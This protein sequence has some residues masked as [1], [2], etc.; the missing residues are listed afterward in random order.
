MEFELKYAVERESILDQIAASPAITGRMAEA[1]RTIPMETT[2]FD[3]EDQRLTALHWTLRRRM[4][5]GTPVVTLKTPAAI[6][7]ARNE[8]E[9]ESDDVL[10][11]VPALIALGA[12]KEL[13]DLTAIFPICGAEFTRRAVLLQLENCTAELALDLGR[14]F[15]GD[16]STPLCELELELKSGPPAAMFALAKELAAAYG[17]KEEPRSKFFRASQL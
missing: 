3:T 14:L 2:Y 7:G 9:T 10:S 1:V 13:A 4:E 12:P 6:P 5:G 8:W 11:A 16:R 15:R 17:L